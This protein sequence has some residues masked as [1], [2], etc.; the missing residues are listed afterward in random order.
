MTIHR[1]DPSVRLD[2]SQP[3]MPYEIYCAQPNMGEQ[4]CEKV[5]GGCR[6]TDADSIWGMKYVPV[7]GYIFFFKHEYDAARFAMVFSGRI[8]TNDKPIDLQ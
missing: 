6:I 1:L 4:W 3:G 7:A 8:Y 5:L 2:T